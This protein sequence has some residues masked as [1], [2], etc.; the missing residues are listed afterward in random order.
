MS[1][2]RRCLNEVR[3]RQGDAIVVE[4]LPYR[5]GVAGRLRPV[6]HPQANVPPCAG[7]DPTL[8]QATPPS[9]H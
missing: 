1:L 6:P 2:L 8:T 4:L 7:G 3:A 5:N 9:Q